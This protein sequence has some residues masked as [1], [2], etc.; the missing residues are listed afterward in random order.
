MTS[1]IPIHDVPEGKVF[2]VV[3]DVITSDIG[4]AYV[5]KADDLKNIGWEEFLEPLPFEF[6][7]LS[8]TSETRFG[9]SSITGS[10]NAPTLYF[11]LPTGSA[12][13]SVEINV[14]SAG[15]EFSAI[16]PLWVQVDNRSPKI[17]L[18]GNTFYFEEKNLSVGDHFVRA[19]CS[20]D[21]RVS[22]TI[23]VRK[24]GGYGS[25]FKNARAYGRIGQG[26]DMILQVYNSN[27]YS[28]GKF[29]FIDAAKRTIPA[30]SGAAYSINTNGLTQN[31]SSFYGGGQINSRATIL[32]G[33]TSVGY[34]EIVDFFDSL[35]TTELDLSN[36]YN[37]EVEYN[38]S[39]RLPVKLFVAPPLVWQETGENIVI[40]TYEANTV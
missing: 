20:V 9:P 30:E 29:L 2:G 33:E 38:S 35:S 6:E 27:Q 8:L 18:T 17:A 14:N 5:K 7:E 39:N 25:Q 21:R 36:V 34:I 22:L 28:R 24:I 1:G 23:T 11:N 15:H 31:L 13:I 10:T 19:S 37:F 32:T 16:T 3:G 4:K 40:R 12:D 26:A